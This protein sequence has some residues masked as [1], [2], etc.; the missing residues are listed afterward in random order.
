MKIHPDPHLDSCFRLLDD[1]DESV[2]VTAMAEL[3]DHE[4]ELG[5]AP[6]LMQEIGS[7][8]A[9][10]RIHQLQAAI[11]IRRRRRNFS[12]YLRQPR[13]DFPTG[14]IEVHLQ[15]FDNDSRPALE[16]AWREF[17]G[18]AR[19]NH[20]D[21]LPQVA[22]FMKRRGLSAAGETTMQP[23]LYCIGTVLEANLGSAA[24]LAG[25]AQ[26]LA[27]QGGLETRVVQLLGDFALLDGDGN[28][29][30]PLR[31]WGLMR[32]AGVENCEFWEPRTLLRYLSTMLFSHAVTS[33][34]FRYI[35]TIGQA[36]AD[37]P[38]GELPETFPYPYRS[39]DDEA[40]AAEDA[41]AENSQPQ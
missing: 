23:E 2:A 15:W 12:R 31:E 18:A 22:G 38:D 25:V 39:A 34:S 29:L 17:A 40:D 13:I 20:L 21:S 8:L 14:L 10:K 6:G 27:A 1:E 24:L 5:D 7:P 4:E 32:G 36:L 30:F 26:E 11:T 19:R 9:R 41:A 33:D 3:L 16:R 37:L 35:Q 28:V